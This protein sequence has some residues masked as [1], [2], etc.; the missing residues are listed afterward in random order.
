MPRLLRHASPDR[1][2]FLEIRTPI[3]RFPLKTSP[4]SADHRVKQAQTTQI[5]KASSP[6]LPSPDY[7]DFLGEQNH[8]LIAAVWCVWYTQRGARWRP[9]HAFFLFFC[10]PCKTLYIEI[11]FMPLVDICQGGNHDTRHNCGGVLGGL[12]WCWG[13][14]APSTHVHSSSVKRKGFGHKS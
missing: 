14:R 13:G 6:R 11:A 9:P 4:D 2:D 10:K 8:M 1:L 5:T 7:P 12:P 3:A